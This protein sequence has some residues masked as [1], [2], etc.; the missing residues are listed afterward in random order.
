[1][2][3]TTDLDEF[4]QLHRVHGPFQATVGDLTANGYRLEIACPCGVTFERWVTAQDAVDDL[5]REHL[6]AERN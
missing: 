6:R 2:S 3:L 5:L 4:V 1:M